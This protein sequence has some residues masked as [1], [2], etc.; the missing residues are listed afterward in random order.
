M[1]MHFVLIQMFICF[2]YDKTSLK[3]C[4]SFRFFLAVFM[5][6][7]PLSELCE[8]RNPIDAR[9]LVQ[10]GRVCGVGDRYNYVHKLHITRFSLFYQFTVFMSTAHSVADRAE[11]RD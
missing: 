11:R 1:V 10:N 2:S 5:E 6:Q 8:K 3:F 4:A 7:N 9:F